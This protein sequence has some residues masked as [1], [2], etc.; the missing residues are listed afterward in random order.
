MLL[1]L[2]VPLAAFLCAPPLAAVGAQAPDTTA[3]D[4]AA[5]DTA[6]LGAVLV[7]ATRSPTPARAL[8]QPAIVLQGAALR[9]RGVTTVAQAL[10]EVPGATVVQSG[11]YGAITS[12][13]LRGGESR[14]TRV[15]VDGV[16]V[17]EPGGA[18]YFDNLTLDDVDR[19][20]VVYGP[21]SAL[22]GAD[23]MAGVV[24]IFTRRGG[25]APGATATVRGGSYGTRDATLSAH[26]GPGVLSGSVGAGWH[27]TD[28]TYAFN[29]KY[30]NGTLD[31]AGDLRPDARTRVQFTGRY[32]A[33][34]YHY[35]TDYTGA[36]V[37]STS[38]GTD[39]RL[40]LSVA[41]A[42]QIAPWLTLHLRAGAE[43]L[44]RL[45]EDTQR[46]TS[47]APGTPPAW[48]K[49]S[50]PEQDHRRIGVARAQLALGWFAATIGSEYRTERAA[51][52]YVTRRSGVAPGAAR[53]DTVP[54]DAGHRVTHG[55]FAGVQSDPAR[56]VVVDGSVRRDVHSDFGVATTGR[57]GVSVALWAGARG[58][59]SYG[60]AFSAPS[61]AET[62]G[63]AYNRANPA[64]RPE[65][66]HT[67]DVGLE[68]R[69]ARGSLV[70]NVGAFDQRFDQLIQYVP[71][72]Y[73]S[74]W[75]VV[76]PAYY[77]NLARAR[78]S[79]YEVGAHLRLARA[80]TGSASY[81]QTVARVIAVA[82]GAAGG[83]RVGDA[84]LRRPSHSGQAL[85]TYAP[86]RWQG[87][88]AATY[89]GARPDQDFTRYPSPTVTLAGYV[90]VDAAASADV[91]RA[92]GSA[93]ALTVR[94]EN[95]LGR[96]YEDVLHF[97]APGR[98]IFVGLRLGT[99]R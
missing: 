7:T 11:S 41:G 44:R 28:G 19:I 32:G 50:V 51:T 36:P 23:A 82:P 21:G 94:A 78:S 60:S 89:V 80:L 1:R 35:P 26:S 90:R 6:A 4:T 15:L 75:S 73:A 39:H 56:R 30:R 61:F 86:G 87:S 68:Q 65:Q 14:Y 84:L 77:D 13:F 66:G 93:L 70:L 81:T 67:L 47:G 25:A 76:V 3:R 29:N 42:R 59:A 53:A 2:A 37:D 54:G 40:V 58:R 43:E 71:A 48:V 52:A 38:Y 24:Q 88:L 45:S 31:A 72:V 64:L 10:R 92:R 22:Y 34:E 74:D 8:S 49:S 63:S 57:V 96:R 17:N 20:E 27:A 79:G 46:D 33:S 12:L 98:A 9:A 55:Y 99:T 97:P 83:F 91:A 5:S 69:L 16:P 62:Q 95:L 85:V 18:M